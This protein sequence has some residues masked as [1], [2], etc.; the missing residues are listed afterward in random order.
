MVHENCIRPS[1]HPKD[2][3]KE[4]IES[5]ADRDLDEFYVEKIIGHS[6]LGKKPKKW[7]IRVC[8]LGYE[9]E[10]DTMLD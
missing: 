8:W 3:P 1:K 7:K 2:M 4:K 5:L 6:G 10:D 9:P